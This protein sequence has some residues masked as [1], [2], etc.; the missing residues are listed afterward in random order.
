[1]GALAPLEARLPAPGAANADALLDL[2]L[3]WAAEKGLTLYPAQEQAVLELFAGNNVIL[4][5]PT[6]SGKSLVATAACFWAMAWGVR[7]YYTVP[8]KALASEKFFALSGELGAANVGL[9]TGDASVNPR[10]PVICCTAEV[11]MN[12]ALRQGRRA[13]VGVVVMDEFH[14]YADRDRGVAWQVPLLV[15]EDAQFLLMSATLGDTTPFEERL[16]RL[17]DR[18]TVSVAGGERPVPL[19]FTYAETPLHES[20]QELLRAGKAPIYLVSFTQRAAA[21]RAQDLTSIDVCTKDEKRAILAELEGVRFGASPYGKEVARFVKHGIGVHHAGLLPK[22]RRLVERLAQKGLLKIVSGTDT[23]GVGINVPIRT[24]L[25]TQLCKYDGEKTA[26]LSAREFH[27]IAGRAGRKG[28]DDRGS[29]VV[30]APE[31]VIEN[32]RMEQKAGGDKAKLRKIVR[33]KPP[34]HGYVHWDRAVFERLVAARPE[35]LESRFRL[36]HG[37]L[38]QIL[39][40][41]EGGCRQVGRIVYRSHEPR[42]RKRQHAR[43]ALQM[44]ESLEKTGIIAVED[45]RP[46]VHADLQEDFSLHHALSLWLVEAVGLL[47]RSSPTYALDVLT[48]VEA[49]LEDPE[50]VLRAQVDKLKQRRLAELKAAGVEYDERMAELEKI[51]HPKPL[52][53]LV[54]AAFESYAERHPWV[55]SDIRPKCVARE[56]V[57]GLSSFSAYVKEYGLSRSEGLL[58]RYL[59]DAYKTLVQTVPEPDKTP[60]VREVEQFLRTIVRQ[61]D[62]TLLDEWE[63]MRA[64]TPRPFEHEGDEAAHLDVTSDERAFAVLVRNEAFALVRALAARDWASA[65]ELAG[66][67]WP[68]RRLEQAL[69]PYFEEHGELRT[70]PE[71]RGPRCF[72]LEKLQNAWIVRQTLLDPDGAGEWTFDAKVDLAR[73]REEGRPVLA[74]ERVGP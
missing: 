41:P 3:S 58:L 47:D 59:S 18:R 30:Q 64:G 70:D 46:R 62:S 61:A 68:P 8:I 34:E 31:H 21:E 44:F 10:A 20:V 35:P 42:A 7:A 15:L 49:V 32:L 40:G 37:M 50:V 52:E 43:T 17:T 57:E 13:D 5:T 53:E 27:Q 29:V 11:L 36:S 22:Y 16:E 60:E 67:G 1:M 69:A 56:I 74:L 45:G 28:F 63:A 12:L 72:S 48:L 9:A 66:E 54:R 4:G 38:L 19:D 2:F 39:A 23:L 6:G 71:A 55:G 51:E 26:L 33:K 65:S 14:Y 25:L 24:V 73:S